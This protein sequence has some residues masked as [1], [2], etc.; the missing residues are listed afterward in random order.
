MGFRTN[1]Q[2]KKYKTNTSPSNT[3]SQNTK[4]QTTKQLKE[5]LKKERFRLHKLKRQKVAKEKA[6]LKHRAIRE[7]IARIR[8]EQSL[9]TSLTTNRI[10]P[11]RVNEI[12]HGSKDTG[13]ANFSVI[14]G[15]VG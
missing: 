15:L 6:Q 9:L 14:P 1:H 3:V 11:D 10:S 8:R 7:S 12:R 5:D 13:G 4:S 2:G